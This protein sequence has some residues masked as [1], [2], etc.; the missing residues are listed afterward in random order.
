[1]YKIYRYRYRDRDNIVKNIVYI[2]IEIEI[3]I[4]VK[5]I[6]YIYNLPDRPPTHIYFF[7]QSREVT[8]SDK[9]SVFSQER[10]KF[11]FL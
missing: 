4:I 8:G 1:M 2:D 11:S 5:N 3:E 7:V 9:V 10:E 6:V